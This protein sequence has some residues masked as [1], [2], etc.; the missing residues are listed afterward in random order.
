MYLISTYRGEDLLFKVL[1]DRKHRPQVLK[2]VMRSEKSE[3]LRR[4]VLDLDL[5]QI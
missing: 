4:K 3:A 1:Y 2:E 5:K